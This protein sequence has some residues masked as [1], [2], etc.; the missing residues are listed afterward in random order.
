MRQSGRRFSLPSMTVVYL[1][2]KDK[3]LGV[4]IAFAI[5]GKLAN[6]VTRNKIRRRI[7]EVVSSYLK[8]NNSLQCDILFIPKKNIIEAQYSDIEAQ[9]KKFFIFLE[10]NI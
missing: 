2:K 4:R 8:A 3:E 9:V 6:A 1:S 7:K 10:K 5:S